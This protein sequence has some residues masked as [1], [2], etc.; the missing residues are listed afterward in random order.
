MI[1]LV[2][3]VPIKVMRSLRWTKNAGPSKEGP[4]AGKEYVQHKPLLI[5]NHCKSNA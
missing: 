5:T 2:K 4:A 1:I 3:Q